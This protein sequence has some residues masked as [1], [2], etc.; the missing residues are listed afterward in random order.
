[1][2]RYVDV[3]IFVQ[4]LLY[5]EIC[6]KHCPVHPLQQSTLKKKK[7]KIYEPVLHEVILI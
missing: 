6:L 4:L 5:V 3:I 7:R 1:M 2:I